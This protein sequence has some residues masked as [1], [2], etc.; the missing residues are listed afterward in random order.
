[1]GE[2][3]RLELLLLLLLLL[4]A[5]PDAGDNPFTTFVPFIRVCSRG[6]LKRDLVIEE[7]I[8]AESHAAGG[9]GSIRV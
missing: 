1:M 6:V 5:F 8:L 3:L 2:G 4:G 9:C 7:I